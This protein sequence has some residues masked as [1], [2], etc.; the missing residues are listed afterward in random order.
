MHTTARRSLS[1]YG[2]LCLI[3]AYTR[4]FDP[5]LLASCL[6]ALIR[7]RCGQT[8]RKASTADLKPA[9]GLIFHVLCQPAF[10]RSTVRLYFNDFAAFVETDTGCFL[11]LGQS[12]FHYVSISSCPAKTGSF[13]NGERPGDTLFDLDTSIR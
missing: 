13:L 7:I 4:S 10:E 11:S 9:A 3:R 6:S 5:F 12:G 8:D 1:P 2:R